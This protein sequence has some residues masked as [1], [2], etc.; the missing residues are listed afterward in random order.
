MYQEKKIACGKFF[1]SKNIKINIKMDIG[2]TRLS[3]RYAKAG[4]GG[5]CLSINLNQKSN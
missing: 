4:G 3:G 1:Q 2:L 5:A